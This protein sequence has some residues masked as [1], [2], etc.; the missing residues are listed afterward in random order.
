MRLIAFALSL[1]LVVACGDDSEPENNESDAGARDAAAPSDA[2]DE[3][4]DDG[5][6]REV[7]CTDQSVSDLMLFDKPATGRV[8]EENAPEGE[9]ITAIDATGGGLTPVE[10]Y[11][12]ARFT[13]TGLKKLNITDEDAFE[14]NEWHIALRRYVIRLN[15]G[16]SGPGE[17][18]AARTAPMTKFDEVSEVADTLAFRTEE[19]FI[20]DNCEYVADT[21]GIGAPATALSSY[22]SYSSCVQMTKNVY[23][24]ALPDDK[25]VKLEVL[26]FYPVENQ[27]TCDETGKVPMPPGGANFRLR[28]SFL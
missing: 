1:C 19:Y 14:S 17:V 16:V 23:V 28:W 5:P 13:D 7:A 22:W 18:T 26:S 8:R 9:F 27:R 20:G 6:V 10:S 15:S 25:H 24:I 21:S 11:V 4:P 12:Y 2:G 3:K